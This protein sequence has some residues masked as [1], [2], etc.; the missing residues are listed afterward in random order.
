MDGTEESKRKQESAETQTPE[1]REQF[2]ERKQLLGKGEGS[3]GIF[4]SRPIVAATTASLGMR[5]EKY[6][7]GSNRHV[8]SGKMWLFRTV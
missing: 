3:A 5:H 7:T 1:D 6:R 4:S 2:D 8:R